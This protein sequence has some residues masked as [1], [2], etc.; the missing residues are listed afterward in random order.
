MKDNYELGVD[1]DVVDQEAFYWVWNVFKEY[2]CGDNYS[3]IFFFH[4]LF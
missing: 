2:C 3:K 4:I 1:Q